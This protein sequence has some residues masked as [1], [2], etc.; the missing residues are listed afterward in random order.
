MNSPLDETEK[1]KDGTYTE[2]CPD[3]SGLPASDENPC[4]VA[5]GLTLEQIVDLT[6][7]FEHLNELVMIH[8]NN[9]GGFSSPV[10]ISELS[11]RYLSSW[12]QRY[13]SGSS[14]A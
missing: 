14:P 3:C 5:A 1:S 4:D 6:G 11:G 9:S 8:I 12:K 7:E 10:H 13:V 2:T